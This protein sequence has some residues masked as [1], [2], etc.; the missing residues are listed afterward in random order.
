MNIL[1]IRHIEDCLDGTVIKEIHLDISLQKSHILA[2]GK[3]GDLAY[4]P[5]F[6]RPFFTLILPEK[7]KIKGVEGNRMIRVL[8]YH[9]AHQEVETFL[10]SQLMTL[11]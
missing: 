3:T 7:A 2:L 5:D 1:E 6:A 9:S 4:Y 11:P 8:Y 10:L